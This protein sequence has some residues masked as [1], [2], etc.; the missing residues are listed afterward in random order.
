M[1]LG[2]GKQRCCLENN[3]IREG[4]AYSYKMGRKIGSEGTSPPSSQA[5]KE[6]AGDLY[7]QD[8]INVL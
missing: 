3:H 1:T 4:R 6:T 5:V 7:L 2:D 8:S